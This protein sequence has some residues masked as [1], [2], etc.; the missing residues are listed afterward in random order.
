MIPHKLLISPIV[1]PP[2]WSAYLTKFLKMVSPFL[3]STMFF[4]FIIFMSMSSAWSFACKSLSMLVSSSLLNWSVVGS[5]I[6]MLDGIESKQN[7]MSAG[8]FEN[9]ASISA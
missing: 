4:A 1:F 6:S 8:T 9:R 5:I 3:S 7:P 2:D